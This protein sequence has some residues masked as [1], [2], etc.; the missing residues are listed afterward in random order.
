[1]T[2]LSDLQASFE[3]AFGSRPTFVVRAPGRVNLIGE[4]TDYNDGFVFPAAIDY[5]VRIAGRPRDDGEV[6]LWSA[7]FGR[8]ARFMLGSGR[9]SRRGGW[10][11][12]VRGVGVILA[13]EGYPLRGMDAVVTGTVPLSSG[14]SSSAALEVASCLAYEV[15]GDFSI[16]PKR[17]ALLCQRAEREYVGVQCGIMDQFISSL[18]RADHALMID[19]RSLDYRP[20]PLPSSGVSIVIGN[21]NKPRGL[22]DSAYNERRAQ[23]EEGVALLQDAL[24][25]I[26]ALRDVA[27]SDLERHAAELDPV[28]LRRCRHV[29]LENE[30]VLDSVR[31]LEAGDLDRFGL[32]MNE[33][34]DSLRD[35]YE[36]SCAELDAMVEA[37]RGVEGVYGSRM[38]GAGFGG[39]TV[40]L[41]ADSA[42]E[43]FQ[44]AVGAEYRRRTGREATFYVCRASA[45][46]ERLL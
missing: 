40:S 19:T 13:S 17:R 9:R 7:L 30:R 20:V 24:P 43:E 25:G 4:H 3:H 18:G 2:D 1:M 36:V 39:C 35:D 5:D 42:V 38:T 6:R 22:V 33:S 12:Y 28:V 34:H 15:A 31:A 27:P 46:A 29:V 16:E 11:N 32:L 14:L 45:G 10:S 21:T 23:C 44:S 41:V 37:A 26:R 8:R